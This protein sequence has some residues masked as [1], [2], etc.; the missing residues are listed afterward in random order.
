M[1]FDDNMDRDQAMGGGGSANSSSDFVSP[2]PDAR[3]NAIV[4]Q[5]CRFESSTSMPTNPLPSYHRI[6]K[7]M[8]SIECWKT[9]HTRK[10]FD[11]AMMA[12]AL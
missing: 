11:G 8:S 5:F 1:R 7:L 3:P 2:S 4:S 12:E 6:I 9:L 10:W